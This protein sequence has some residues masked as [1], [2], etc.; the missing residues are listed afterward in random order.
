MARTDKRDSYV[1]HGFTHHPLYFVWTGMMRRCYSKDHKFYRH[2]G[3]R[4]ITVC[5]EWH[6][7]AA[8]IFDMSATYKEGL[9]LDRVDNDKG[10]SPGNC[11]WSTPREQGNNRRSN[12]LL[13]IGETVK[14]LSQWR[15]HFGIKKPSYQKRRQLGWSIIEALTTPIHGRKS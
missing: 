5:S 12:L 7:I 1:K 13:S 11:K 2:Y 15:E 4:G 8:F 6:D 10:Y 14:T 3:G 9:L